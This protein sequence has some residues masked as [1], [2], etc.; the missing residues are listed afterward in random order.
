MAG[1]FVRS[2]EFNDQDLMP[3]RV[4]KA[5]GN[6]SPELEWSDVPDTTT[7]LA[8]CVE[9][10][11]APR[12]PF[13]HWVVTGIDPGTAGVGE[14]QVPA[15]GREWPNSFGEVGYSG[16]MPPRGDNP[17]RYFFRIYALERPLDLPD[18][19]DPADIFRAAEDQE[20]AS[21]VIVGTFAR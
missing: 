20:V 11:D 8:L 5:D 1:I 19:P 15:G 12:K 21:G 10:G 14:G 6:R 2:S 13:L 18:R 9:D 4:S 7:E 17:H 16:P 3:D